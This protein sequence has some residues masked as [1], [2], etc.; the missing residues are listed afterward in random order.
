MIDLD[1]T[2]GCLSSE[3]VCSFERVSP[4]FTFST[5][6]DLL[7]TYSLQYRYLLY[8]LKTGPFKS[9]SQSVS[10]SLVVI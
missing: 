6:P 3:N 4:R 7:P 10:P 8:V 2:L 9:I 5:R 1:W